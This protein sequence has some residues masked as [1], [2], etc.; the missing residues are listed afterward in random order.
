MTT[1]TLSGV[2][3]CHIL[4]YERQNQRKKYLSFFSRFI[5][6]TSFDRLFFSI[7]ELLRVFLNDSKYSN[8]SIQ[9]L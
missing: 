5:N 1:S 3:Y 8:A 2:D 6:A 7:S 4:Y 9:A